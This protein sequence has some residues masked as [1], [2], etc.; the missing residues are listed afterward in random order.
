MI[1]LFTLVTWPCSECLQLRVRLGQAVFHNMNG[2][3]LRLCGAQ[4]FKVLVKA[5]GSRKMERAIQK[6]I[7]AGQRR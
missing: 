5:R 7:E 6:T 1:N 2:R 3:S 4:P